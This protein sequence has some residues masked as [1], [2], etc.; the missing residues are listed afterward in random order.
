M[1]IR[2]GL[3]RI[4]FEV[5]AL[6]P[7]LTALLFTAVLATIAIRILPPFWETNDDVGMAM[8]LDGYGLAAYPSPGILFPNIL[9]GYALAALPQIGDISRY[10]LA[11]I[12]LNLLSI[13]LL[14][15]ALCLLTGNYVLTLSV[16]A[17]TSLPPL[18]F[19]QFTVL[20][21][22]LSVA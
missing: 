16:I 15:R 5:P 2:A 11:A 17:L 19:P 13:V 10:G 6:P 14:C 21:G 9:Y 22:M 18:V 20:A 8:I 12:S 4:P 3:R 1:N 7:F